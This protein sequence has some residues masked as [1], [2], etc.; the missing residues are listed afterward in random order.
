MRPISWTLFPRTQLDKV[1]P[2]PWYVPFPE[3]L[4]GAITYHR[5]H[6]SK[7][8]TGDPKKKKLPWPRWRKEVARILVI[9]CTFLS[10]PEYW[11]VG[12][13]DLTY[14][15]CKFLRRLFYWETRLYR[16]ATGFDIARR[17]WDA[18]DTPD[19][20]DLDN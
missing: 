20:D 5:G 10:Q 8:Y 19:P 13:F 4:R 16:W 6:W 12:N 9:L 15:Q 14:P 17:N 18:D 3:R 7:A 1:P 2:Y 11:L